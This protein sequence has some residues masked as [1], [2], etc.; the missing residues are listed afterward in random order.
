MEDGESLR[1]RS[2]EEA[3]W[4]QAGHPPSSILHPLREHPLRQPFWLPVW[5]LAVR[6]L[7]RFFRQ[8]T[9]IVGALGQPVIFWILFGAG[10]SG[11]FRAP[12][13]APEGMAVSYQEYFFPGVAVLIIL[14]TAIFSTISIIEDR[15]EGFLQGVLVAPVPRTALVLGK[16]AGGAA[17]ALIQVGL[18]FAI[19]P[20]LTLAGVAPT[21]DWT[22]TP[23]SLA[24]AVGFAALLALALTALGY[25]IA[26]PMDSTQGFH[27]IMS[28]FLLPMWLLSGAFFPGDDGWLS[29]VI[30]LN[31]LTYG[32]AGLRRLLYPEVTLGTSASLPP[33]GVSIAVTSV[34]CAACLGLAVALT[35]RRTSRDAR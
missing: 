16:V 5:T 25:V 22:F 19:G 9:R 30:R 28:V 17:L 27:A 12:E 23:A 18:F 24:A 1:S 29:W 20:L 31:P 15:R 7:V 34:F 26:W 13:W 32:V 4:Q 35:R 33:L 8:R 21:M 10:L 2:E 14:F 11:S 3:G 6:E